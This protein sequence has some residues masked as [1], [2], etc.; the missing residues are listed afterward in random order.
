MF[1]LGD[2]FVLV[3]GNDYSCFYFYFFWNAYP[4][5]LTVEQGGRLLDDLLVCFFLADARG[6]VGRVGVHLH[7]NVSTKIIQSQ[8]F[9]YIWT[10]AYHF[11]DIG[12]RSNGL[13]KWLTGLTSS[14]DK[15]A[16]PS[17]DGRV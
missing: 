12:K 15:F 17:F 8:L 4:V 5:S 14:T 9:Y 7:G 3:S 2:G 13:Y 16:K 1:V 10:W 6:E 11:Y